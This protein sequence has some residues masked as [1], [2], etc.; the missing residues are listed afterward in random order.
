MNS[1]H[2]WTALCV[3]TFVS[4]WWPRL[5][6]P[7][8]Q[9]A[10]TYYHLLYADNI[11]N[12]GFILP[13][14]HPKFVLPGEYVYPPGYHYLLALFPKKAREEFE[15]IS[16]ALF[17]T[18]L[19]SL[20]LWVAVQ[21][22][23][24][25]GWD[26]LSLFLLGLSFTLS[27][28]F[29]GLGTGPRAYEGT[30]RTLGELMTAIVFVSLWRHWS[31]DSWIWMTIALLVSSLMLNTSRFSGQVL[32]FFC[33]LMAFLLNSVTLL[34]FPL[35]GIIM[36]IILS[37]GHYASVLS[38]QIAHLRLYATKIADSHPTT[39]VRK[40]WIWPKAT[41]RQLA[42]FTL[43]ENVYAI[44][45]AKFTVLL[46]TLGLVAWRVTFSGPT[47]VDLFLLVWLVSAFLVFVV[48]S[49]PTFVFIGEADRYLEYAMVPGFLLFGALLGPGFNYYIL[50]GLVIFHLALYIFNISLLLR[51]QRSFQFSQLSELMASLKTVDPGVILSLLGKAPFEITY[52]SDCTGHRICWFESLSR[53]YISEEE[54]ERY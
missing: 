2:W 1:W 25:F 38:G 49:T 4:R 34:V 22:L 19:V 48:V 23:G 20:F 46:G 33:C 39:M 6:C 37:G 31:D 10:D 18:L 27:P 36:A 12:N 47:D 28:A 3:I 13:A 44:L 50:I 54:Y 42:R 14:R 21:E 5:V 11:R 30:A 26:T 29:V 17:D 32:I 52:H 9:S 35:L 15:K 45:I 53:T 8:P 41:W 16:S 24:P 51:E 7:E 40:R 43:Y